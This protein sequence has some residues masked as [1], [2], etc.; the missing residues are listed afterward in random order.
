MVGASYKRLRTIPEHATRD[1]GQAK[2]PVF[3]GWMA[4]EVALP[5]GVESE[6][7]NFTVDCN[8]VSATP[9]IKASSD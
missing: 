5:N 9:K 1:G 2:I 8:P 7:V 4:L 3:N 6:R